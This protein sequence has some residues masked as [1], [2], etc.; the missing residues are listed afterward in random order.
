MLFCSLKSA[1]RNDT[2]TSMAGKKEL[3]KL[4]VEKRKVTGRKVKLLRKEGILPANIYGREVKSAS[5]QVAL[6]PF[7]PIFKKAGE[8]GLLELKVAGED[9]TRPV[10][11]HNVQL[12]PVTD[13]PLHVDFYQVDLKKKVTAVVPVELMGTSPAVTQKIGILIQPLSGVE[14]EALPTDLPEKLEIDVSNLKE[15]GNAV[16]VADLKLGEEI[17]ILTGVT[18]VLAKIDP[19][20][21]EEVV[22]PPPAAEGAAPVEGEVPAEGAAPTEEGKPVEGKPVEGK[23]GEVKP[24]GKPAAKPAEPPA[25]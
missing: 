12:D 21:K 13:A 24:T 18:E 11:I 6:K 9:K 22:T 2:M 19:P 16:T 7:L 3:P 17:K 5:V 23:S 1:W 15:V 4:E 10:L 20:A 14:V 8:T 25:K